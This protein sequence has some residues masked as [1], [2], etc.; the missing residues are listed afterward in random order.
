MCKAACVEP[1]P[2]SGQVR[3]GIWCSKSA[4]ALCSSS[5]ATKVFC[6]CPSS[7]A[8]MPCTFPTF[9]GSR[10]LK[11]G[12]TINFYEG[13]SWICALIRSR[14]VE[15][16][17]CRNSSEGSPGVPYT[18]IKCPAAMK[19]HDEATVSLPGTRCG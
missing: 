16:W 7:R 19:F 13:Y 18:R 15:A 1:G 6:I 17:C 4:L 10:L 14:Y 9:C 11:A 2:L 8:T 12:H 5:G 3:R